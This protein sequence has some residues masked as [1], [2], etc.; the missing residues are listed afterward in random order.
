MFMI[1]Q[2]TIVSADWLKEH[3]E[4]DNLLIFDASIFKVAAITEKKNNL[5]IRGAQ[6]FDIKN[7]F[8]DTSSDFPNTFPSKEQFEKE[9]RQLGVNNKSIIVVYDDKGIYSSARVWW[10][11]KTFGCKTVF[12]LDGG[13]PEWKKK[14]YPTEVKQPNKKTTGNLKISYNDNKVVFFNDF[15][16]VITAKQ[17]AIIDARSPDRYNCT[18]PEPRQGLRRGRVPGSINV[19]YTSLLNNGKLKPEKEL[20]ELLEPLL[21]GHDSTLVYCGSGITACVIV[22]AA[23]VIGCS[24]LKV[25]DGSWTE[26][27]ALVK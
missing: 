8:S 24:N 18:V 21:K 15:I 17:V 3:L 25:Y 4:D 22:L 27:G 9:A 23:E 10:L 11:F 6:F 14:E 20:K 16:K 1:N 5:Q 13:F 12:V 7:T 19:P 26:Y 2:N